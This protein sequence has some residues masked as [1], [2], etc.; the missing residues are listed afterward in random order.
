MKL[1]RY[2]ED[3][4]YSTISGASRISATFDTAEAS[5]RSSGET[6]KVR[7]RSTE[8]RV[9]VF[10]AGDALGPHH[11]SA[12]LAF[13]RLSRLDRLLAGLRKTLQEA[14]KGA[15]VSGDV[16][17]RLAASFPAKRKPSVSM[18]S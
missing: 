1:S 2:G 6:L 4:Q 11:H 5:T 18:K 13:D 10:G 15:H 17:R 3:F 8:H 7:A 12:K 9:A 16:C 14:A